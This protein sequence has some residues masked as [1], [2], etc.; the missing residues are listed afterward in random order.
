[1]IYKYKS[2]DNNSYRSCVNEKKYSLFCNFFS[3]FYNN[4]TTI[5]KDINFLD[6][7]HYFYGLNNI[8]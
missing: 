6:G 5:E 4:K 3:F 8:S 1:M 7:R 2:A